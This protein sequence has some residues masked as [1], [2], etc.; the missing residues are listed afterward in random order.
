[1]SQAQAASDD[2]AEAHR[3]RLLINY[4][5]DAIDLIPQRSNSLERTP[6]LLADGFLSFF[7]EEPLCVP[8]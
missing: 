3:L 2:L 8:I 5:P 6:C 7:R 4:R 1:M